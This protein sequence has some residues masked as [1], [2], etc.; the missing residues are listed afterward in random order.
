MV[1]LRC[2]SV[3]LSGLVLTVALALGGG[4]IVLARP[5]TPVPGLAE[6]PAHVHAGTCTDHDADLAFPLAGVAFV[7]KPVVGAASSLPVAQS[8]TNLDVALDDLIETAHAIDVH[9]SA[10]DL[11]T[12]IDCGDIGGPVTVTDG[13][14][15]ELAVGLGEQ[16][17]SGS[18]GVAL[19]REGRD[20]GTTVS[21]YLT[22][23]K[24]QDVGTPPPGGAA[25]DEVAIDIVDFDFDPAEVAVPVGTTVTWT[26]AGPTD[27]TTVAYI[28]GT[29][30]WA[31]D[32]LH[33][34]ATFSYTF[35]EPGTFP[36]RCGLHQGMLASITVVEA[37]AA[38]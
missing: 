5:T 15:R 13:G 31:S 10:A 26:N 6:R 34:G 38:G 11:E 16:S 28:D 1:R 22:T 2:G 8:V 9:A 17:A 30:V 35:A 23:P 12:V 37:P 29:I 18:T 3:G 36:Y 25:T 21:I 32:I 14:T 24:A 27:H 4:G 20:G 33:P 7:V 19:L